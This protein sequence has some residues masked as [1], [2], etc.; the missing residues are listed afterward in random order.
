MSSLLMRDLENLQQKYKNAISFYTNKLS[1]SAKF[2]GVITTNDEHSFN[3]YEKFLNAKTE[4]EKLLEIY[5]RI[6]K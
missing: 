5:K 6:R 3:Q 1:K 2:Y 4:L